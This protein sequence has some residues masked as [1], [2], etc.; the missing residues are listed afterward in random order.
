[1]MQPQPGLVLVQPDKPKELTSS[2]I[3]I[4]EAAKRDTDIGVVIVCGEG[5]EDVKKGDRVMFAKN[6]VTL[7]LYG[8]VNYVMV[9]NEDIKAVL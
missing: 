4:P 3:I 7:M 5:V 9:K 2:G 8:G 6:N 1:M